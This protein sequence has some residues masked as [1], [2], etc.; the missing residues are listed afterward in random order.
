MK[1][2]EKYRPNTLDDIIGQDENIKLIKGI[3]GKGN[4]ENFLFYGPPGTGKTTTAKAL[5]NDFDFELFDFNASDER[6]IDFIRNKIKDISQTGSINGLQKVIFLDEADNLSR[7]AQ[8]AF[9]RIMEDYYK[10][11]IFILSANERGNLIDALASRCVELHFAKLKKE[12]MAKILNRVIDGEGL[13]ITEETKNRIYNRANGDGRK[14]ME[15]IVQ[16]AT[17]AKIEEKDTFDI[18]TY[19]EQIKAGEYIKAMGIIRYIKF[20]DLSTELIKY[21]SEKQQWEEIIKIG[22]WIL[23]NPQPDD[24][25]G[26]AG[27]TAYLIK[28]REA[29][30]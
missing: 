8:P 25:I 30:T 18:N 11:N 19:L 12:D 3:L 4:T 13:T 1:L 23:P 6:G 28:R 17:G 14:L 24:Y 21:F 10:N 15:L 26:R 9:R 29:L 2:S 27:I 7:D 22:D 20:K 5:A 16:V